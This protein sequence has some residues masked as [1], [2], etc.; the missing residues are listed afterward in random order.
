MSISTNFFFVNQLILFVSLLFQKCLVILIAY[1]CWLF[2]Y[3]ILRSVLK[4]RGRLLKK[5]LI[6]QTHKVLGGEGVI[7]YLLLVISTHGFVSLFD[8]LYL[9]I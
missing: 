3:S 1:C 8:D 9:T 7:Y 4:Y 5:S 6:I 2:F